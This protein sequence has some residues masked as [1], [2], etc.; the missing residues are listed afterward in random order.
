MSEEKFKRAEAALV[1]QPGDPGG[2]R[3]TIMMPDM[4]LLH[5]R[6]L[7]GQAGFSE[8]DPWQA[9]IVVAQIALMQASTADPGTYARIGGDITKLQTLGCLACY[10]PDAFGEIVQAMETGSLGAI[11]ALG[12]RWVQE[13]EKR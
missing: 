11:K 9:L 12:E 2:A 10:K 5:R 4:C 7:V 6:L 8:A 3:P 13:A 1:G